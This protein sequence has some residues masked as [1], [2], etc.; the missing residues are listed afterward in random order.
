[1]SRRVG[2]TMPFNAA[3]AANY[4]TYV[5][6]VYAMYNNGKGG[7]TPGQIGMAGY[8]VHSYVIMSDF[9]PW[10]SMPEFYGVIA[11]SNTTAESILVMRG[12]IGWTEWF[13]NMHPGM[14]PFNHAPGDVE[15]GFNQI[16]ETIKV[17]PQGWSPT[18]PAALSLVPGATFAEQVANAIATHRRVTVAAATVTETLTIAGHSLGSALLTLYVVENV[19]KGLLKTPL[20][21]LFASPRV[22]DATFV[23]TYN[24]MTGVTT[25]RIAN[26]NDLVT[27]VPPEDWG[28][29]DVNTLVPVDD[30]GKV[31]DTPTCHHAMTTYMFLLNPA[32]FNPGDCAP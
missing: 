13:D 19:A 11:T 15:A 27:L 18:A 7:L 4:G 17:V 23:N 32:V 29:R 2:I 9:L 6:N 25:W 30:T 12:T 20:V 21:Y 10:K 8:T 24:T 1:M 31:K 28:F 26:K 14:V 5:N 22:G 3:E 16:Y